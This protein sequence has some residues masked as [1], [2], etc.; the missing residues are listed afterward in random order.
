M[1]VSGCTPKTK[2]LL[3]VDPRKW[4]R[5]QLYVGIP[6]TLDKL[7]TMTNPQFL[8]ARNHQ[9]LSHN[10][11]RRRL[12]LRLNIHRHRYFQVVTIQK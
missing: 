11:H 6:L 8:S 3:T 4:R 7:K 12:H 1:T 2:D 5:R 10:T 9:M